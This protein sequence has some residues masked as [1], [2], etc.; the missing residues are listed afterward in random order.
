MA[1]LA[2]TVFFS[3]ILA[4]L[5]ALAF[6]WDQRNRGEDGYDRDSLRPLDEDAPSPPPT[7]KL[8]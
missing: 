1:A 3:V 8:P 6:L 5:A 2:L 4:L 7:N